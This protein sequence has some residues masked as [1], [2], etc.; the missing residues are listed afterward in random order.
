MEGTHEYSRAPQQHIGCSQMKK[1]LNND[2]KRA[3]EVLLSLQASAFNSFNERRRYE[4]RLCISLWTASAV[5]LG[6]LL[7]GEIQAISPW[8]K[9]GLT[10]VAALMMVLHAIWMKGAGRRN[11]ADIHVAYFWEEKTRDILDAAYPKKLET[12]L[13]A[14]RET[15]GRLTSWSFFF[16]LATTILLA[17]AI[18]CATWCL[19][20]TQQSAVGNSSKC[21]PLTETPH[22]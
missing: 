1:L 19:K 20:D 12:E 6:F 13:R 4:W 21:A 17:L 8:L 9:W 2:E 7:K 14:L 15:S 18:I 22:Q 11:R 16:Q 10:V 5:L 3:A